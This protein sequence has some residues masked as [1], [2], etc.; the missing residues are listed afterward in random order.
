MNLMN[1]VHIFIANFFKINFNITLPSTTRRTELFPP[2]RSSHRS[3]C[4]FLVYPMCATS[5]A[6][7]TFL[8]LITLI[9]YGE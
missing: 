4:G 5:L 7:L 6:Y 9:I 8:D 1:P 2:Y 3:V